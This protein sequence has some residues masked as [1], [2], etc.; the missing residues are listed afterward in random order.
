M[1][2]CPRPRRVCI[3]RLEWPRIQALTRRR[4]AQHDVVVRAWVVI[5]LSYG[6]GPTRVALLAGCSDR[7]VR[8]WRA[9]WAVRPCIESLLDAPRSGRPPRVSLE[10]RCEIV[11]LACERPADNRVVFRDVWSYQAVADAL[12]AGSGERVSRSTVRRVL[13]AGG[14]RPH[15]VRYWLH[16]PDPDFRAKVARICRLYKHPPEDA[17]VVCVDEKPLQALARRHPIHVGRRG[18]VRHEFEYRRRGTGSLL[19]SF[20]I[21]TGKVFGRVVRHRD[22]RALLAFLHALAQRYQGRC[23]YVIWDNLNLHHDGRDARWTRFNQEH[24][25]R[26][27]FV[28]TPLH[29]SWVNQVEIWFSI[30]QRRVLRYG[31]FESVAALAHDVVGFVRHWN[32][33]EARPFRWTFAGRFVDTPVR[34]AA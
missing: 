23:V 13:G 33:A 26:F 21:R 19:A 1:D 11:Q 12:Y 5:W 14:W 6:H 27:R 30:L 18:V 7:L 16:S 8:K 17:V 2:P 24:G 29:A 3:P 28:H 25:H 22:A 15:R 4:H 10:T 32:R 9:R 20:D 31:S 34:L